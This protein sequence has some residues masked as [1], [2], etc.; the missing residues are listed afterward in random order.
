MNVPNW[1]S[2]PLRR[3]CLSD[4]WSAIIEPLETLTLK[5]RNELIGLLYDLTVSPEHTQQS[6]RLAETWAGVTDCGL[7]EELL[8]QDTIS[9]E[10]YVAAA[11]AI[12]S[13]TVGGTT[14]LE[15]VYRDSGWRIARV[16][17][18]E[19]VLRYDPRLA[20]L[21]CLD[22]LEE[23]LFFAR[24]RILWIIE[25][26]GILVA[27]IRR[28]DDDYDTIFWRQPELIG[29]AACPSAWRLFPLWLQKPIW[30]RLLAFILGEDPM[31][32]ERPEVRRLAEATFR[33]R[34]DRAIEQRNRL[35][36]EELVQDCPFWLMSR[37]EL[38]Q[39][40]PSEL[41]RWYRLLRV[42][43][44]ELSDVGVFARALRHAAGLLEATTS[45]EIHEAID[46]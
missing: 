4:W 35:L 1:I 19:V 5:D 42:P 17:R 40:E 32:Y 13:A 26:H 15:D 37:D 29:I 36:L 45:G 21:L 20:N 27:T 46:D 31:V 30:G 8:D 2:N 34:V 43:K 22:R 38:L 16:N 24:E 6:R 44:K 23:A 7:L 28:N 41:R 12:I 9:Q 11:Q 33:T 10:E 39:E 25:R 14:G 3:E 18:P